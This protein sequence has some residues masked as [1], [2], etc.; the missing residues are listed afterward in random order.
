VPAIAVA[1][2]VWGLV[3]A[4]GGH[5]PAAS[6][7]TTYLEG[8][9]YGGPAVLA[10]FDPATGHVGHL[11][12]AYVDAIA[13]GGKIGVSLD[14]NHNRV[15]LV[16]L[17][18]GRSGPP[19][20]VG[21]APGTVAFSPDG[22]TAYVVNL[23]IA[24]YEGGGGVPPPGE[25]VTDTVTPVN[26]TTGRA[27]RPL[28]VCR[29]PAG[30]AYSAPTRLLVVG[31]RSRVVLVDTTDGRRVRTFRL[32][33]AALWGQIAVSPS[34]RTAV[35]GQ[36]GFGDG[37]IASG[38]V[39][40]IDL[41]TR[42]AG[43]PLSI[44]GNRGDDGAAQLQ[45]RPGD[46]RD[47]YATTGRTL[48]STGL[49][50]NVVLRVDLAD[51]TVSAPLRLDGD[52]VAAVHFWPGGRA[53]Y[54]ALDT[55]EGRSSRWRASTSLDSSGRIVNLPLQSGVGERFPYD[56]AGQAPYLVIPQNKRQVTVVNL[57]RG[58]ARAVKVPMFPQSPLTG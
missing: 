26:L 11:L 15:E 18:T 33:D 43:R 25:H 50:E 20:R 9:T 19:I 36:T 5:R 56:F 55:P 2:V 12:K 57:S 54:I 34:G 8:A 21:Q 52:P 35:V 4:T 7:P 23:G 38:S 6:G 49:G 1:A 30:A 24:A 40:P 3:L 44:G 37:S 48:N 47:V 27:A 53:G 58:Q 42:T 51:R 13:P 46:N 14:T 29:N 31:C 32:G 17:R 22:R 39:V 16:D 45:F 41:Q 10:T 28:T